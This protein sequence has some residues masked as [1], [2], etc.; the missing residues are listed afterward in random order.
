MRNGKPGKTGTGGGMV[1]FVRRL[2]NLPVYLRSFISH[3]RRNGLIA[4]IVKA[5][6]F[7]RWGGGPGYGQGFRRWFARN[8][9]GSE[10]APANEVF[11]RPAML[12]VGPLDLPQ[13][14][15]YR[16]VQKLELLQGLGIECRMSHVEDTVRV[17]NLMQTATHLMFYRVVA[18]PLVEGYLDEGRRL[19]LKVAYDIDDPIFDADTYRANRNLETLDATERAQL[20]ASAELHLD[21]MRQCDMVTVSTLT[22]AELVRQRLPVDP[23]IWPNA[24]DAESQGLARLFEG[25]PLPAEEQTV[26]AYMSGSRAH[27]RDFESIAPILAELLAERPFLKLMLVGYVQPPSCLQAHEN[28]LERVPFGNYHEYFAALARAQIVVVPL[29]IDGFNECKSAIRFFEASLLALPTV[30]SRV[31]QFRE[32]IIDGETGYLA[33]NPGEWRAA[34]AALAGNAELRRRIGR[35]ARESTLGEHTV[36]QVSERIAPLLT[37]YRLV[38]S[39]E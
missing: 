18:S 2:R 31:G 17:Y 1:P 37:E 27:D 5:Y 28:Q 35:A 21:V 4:A 14:R 24:V 33:E 32:V 22:M 15:K 29:L 36:E 8:R 39:H 25:R 7:L 30:A 10:V 26:I 11:A 38:T 9:I 12:I 23:W 3:T 6:Q 20:L 13:C 34:L 16:I 19:G